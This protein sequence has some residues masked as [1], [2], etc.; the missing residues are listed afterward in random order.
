MILTVDLY[1]LFIDSV[2]ADKRGNT[3]EIDEFNRCIRLVN[4]EVFDDFLGDFEKDIDNSQDLGEL[5]VHNTEITLALSGGMMVGTLPTNYY[6]LIGKPRD[7]SDTAKRIELVTTLV[8][9]ER[10]DDYLTQATATHPTCVIGGVT[11][12]SEMQIRVRPQTIATIYIDYIKKPTV[13]FL[14]YYINDSTLTPTFLTV[15]TTPAVTAGNTYRDGTAGGV[16]V[17]VT[18]LTENL[19]W[20]DGV[21]QLLLAK[22]LQKTGLTLADDKLLQGG[23]AEEL[24]TK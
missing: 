15:D 14:D 17:T 7:D 1:N 23:M 12:L 4:Q 24:K 13:P 8:D 22:L 11:A 3:K 5:K 2:R 21:I 9:A 6:R 18:S 20:D 19:D 10:Q 16:G